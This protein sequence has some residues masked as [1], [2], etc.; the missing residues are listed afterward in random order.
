MNKLVSIIR[1]ISNYLSSKMHILM[2]KQH[3]LQIKTHEIGKM[4]RGLVEPPNLK[5]NGIAKSF[6][7]VG[8][9]TNWERNLN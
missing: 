5:N 7:H 4:Y 6:I 3:H 1:F 8:G 2:V 9:T